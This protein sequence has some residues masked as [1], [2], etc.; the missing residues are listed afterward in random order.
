LS[1]LDLSAKIG[2]FFEFLCVR[3]SDRNSKKNRDL[4]QITVPFLD[5]CDLHTSSQSDSLLLL[6]ESGCINQ[7]S[8][9]E[10]EGG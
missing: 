6:H 7:K 5:V 3:F 2:H 8:R 10:T 1:T 4:A 9:K